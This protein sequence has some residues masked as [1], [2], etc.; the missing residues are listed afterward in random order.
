MHA[1]MRPIFGHEG[2]LEG[3]L[4]HMDVDRFDVECELMIN[5]HIPSDLGCPSIFKDEKQKSFIHVIFL[6]IDVF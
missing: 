5:T 4:I 1:L 3:I 6:N 2:I